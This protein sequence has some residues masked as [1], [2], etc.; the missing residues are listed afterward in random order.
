MG[1][2]GE[3]AQTNLD[4]INIT[5]NEGLRKPKI[6]EEAVLFLAGCGGE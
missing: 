1:F 5:N 3:S 6:K 4:N 2:R